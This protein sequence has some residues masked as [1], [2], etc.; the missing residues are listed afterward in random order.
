VTAYFIQINKIGAGNVSASITS[1]GIS[2]NYG[3]IINGIVD[4]L[5]ITFILSM[6]MWLGSSILKFCF[7]NKVSIFISGLVLFICLSILGCAFVQWLQL[8]LIN[9]AVSEAGAVLIKILL[10]IGFAIV[11]F[12][13]DR[14]EYSKQNFSANIAKW[15]LW[16][17]NLFIPIV[18]Q[19]IT[20]IT[21]SLALYFINQGDI[22]SVIVGLFFYVLAVALLELLERRLVNYF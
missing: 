21:I 5:L 9:H 22:E 13:L 14:K 6:P 20:F 17:H 12:L 2:S 15:K 3:I 16:V 7:R 4:T 8:V 10:I 18:R 19:L 1:A 11:S